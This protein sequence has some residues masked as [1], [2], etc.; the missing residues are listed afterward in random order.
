MTVAQFS[1]SPSPRTVRYSLCALFLVACGGSSTSN[2]CGPGTTLI[3]G[4]CIANEGGGFV[5]SCGA[6]TKLVGGQC[7]A[8]GSGGGG[9]VS[10]TPDTAPFVSIDSSEGGAPGLPTPPLDPATSGAFFWRAG[11]DSVYLGNWFYGSA[12]DSPAGPH[13]DA[14]LES[15][16]PPRGTS[17]HAR[18]LQGAQLADGAELRLELRHPQGDPVDLSSYLGIAFWARL[19]SNT[20]R[21]IVAVKTPGSGSFLGSESTASPLFA[22]SLAVGPEWQ[23]VVLLFADFRQGVLSGINA[24]QGFSPNAITHFDF[25]VGLQGEAFDLWISDLSLVCSGPCPVA[26]P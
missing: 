19:K 25:I 22:Q 4:A 24:T 23:H 5:T 17:T 14:G 26:A 15:F 8:Q 2:A 21:L 18:H 11:V 6:G 12:G 1:S 3:D 7:V 10:P 16:T 9:A 13:G 20:S